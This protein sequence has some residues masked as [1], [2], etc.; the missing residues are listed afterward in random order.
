MT[1]MTDFFTRIGTRR[2]LGR[3]DKRQR[4]RVS[5][6]VALVVIGV[7]VFAAIAGSLVAPFSPTVQ[8][9]D[10]RLLP[11][12]PVHWLGTDYLGRDVFSRLIW[13]AQPAVI[14]VLVAVATACVI[15]VPWGLLA[16][17]YGGFVDALLMRLADVVIVFP[18]L[19]FAIAVAGSLGPS[20]VSS[21]TAFGLAI[22]PSI[23]RLVRAGVISE[24]HKDYVQIT[25]MYGI[26]S[27]S[28]LVRHILPNS[29]DALAVQVTIYAGVAVLAQAGLDFLGLGVQ[30]PKA[31][32]GADLSQAF[33][34]ILVDPAATIAPGVTIVI[35]VL[36]IYRLGDAVRDR[37]SHD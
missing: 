18:A 3:R 23:A 1:P 30:L 32:W 13:G 33:A 6:V 31:S 17:Y 27:M 8:D 28:R 7:L 37:L 9:L 19:V 12:G 2:G 16:G 24:R 25:R 21:M 4:S 14:G 5:L 11:P 22:S 29:V 35:C 26:T 36:A 15:G 34:Y 10:N 20:I